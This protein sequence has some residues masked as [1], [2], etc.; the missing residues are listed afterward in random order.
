MFSS[1]IISIG[2]P[3]PT[4]VTDSD[5]VLA[6]LKKSNFDIIF[7]DDLLEPKSALEVLKAIKK[8]RP[9]S[10]VAIIC[11]SPSEEDIKEMGKNGVNAILLKPFN[12][13][14]VQKIIDKS[15]IKKSKKVKTNN[16]VEYESPQHKRIRKVLSKFAQS[17]LP[18]LVEFEEHPEQYPSTLVDV[19][20][21]WISLGELKDEEAIKLATPGEKIRVIIKQDIGTIEFYTTIIQPKKQDGK[22]WYNLSFPESLVYV[23]RREAKRVL[24]D[25]CGKIPLSLMLGKE[26]IDNAYLFDISTA[27]MGLRVVEQDVTRFLKVGDTINEISFTYQDFSCQNYKIEVKRV[28]F[29]KEQK[30]SIVAGTFVNLSD[31]EKDHLKK[32]V[33]SLEEEKR[34]SQPPAQA[35]AK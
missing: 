9:K 26:M 24:L 27:N 12:R 21:E 20:E 13:G 1:I 33:E 28:S 25:F 30:L 6:E 8:A 18:V 32:C 29:D 14:L 7:L 19:H 35:K 23:E 10:F 16:N 4:K 17:K 3:I 11:D 34:K 31:D 2:L 15:V 5:G 22:Q